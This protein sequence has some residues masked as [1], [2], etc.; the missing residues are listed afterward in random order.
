MEN[1]AYLELRSLLQTIWSF[2]LCL[3][4][5][6]K[7]FLLQYLIHYICIEAGKNGAHLELFQSP[8]PYT[9]RSLRMV[10]SG[11]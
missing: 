10:L 2:F 8:D 1:L 9:S 4:T 11:E 7:Y 5:A 3:A 6:Q